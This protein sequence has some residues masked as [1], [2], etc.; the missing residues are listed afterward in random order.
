MKV[1]WRTSRRGQ[2]LVLSPD[3]GENEVENEVE[4]GGVR[5]TK[6]GFDAFAKTFGYEPG[7]AEKGIGSM[8][9]AK[10]FVEQFRPWELYEGGHG[11][12]VEAEVRPE[13]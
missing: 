11:L 2:R 7:R 13:A 1:Y 9:E 5:E 6:R 8:E 4:C 3:E 12:T 10:A